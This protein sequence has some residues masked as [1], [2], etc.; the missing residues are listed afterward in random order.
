MEKVWG[1]REMVMDMGRGWL[2]M[3][4]DMVWGWWEVVMDMVWGWW[5]MV[6][7]KGVPVDADALEHRRESS[8]PQPP[9]PPM[10]QR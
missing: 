1:W 9:G 2:E 3:V 6:M 7:D 10:V 5:E 4:T 8:L